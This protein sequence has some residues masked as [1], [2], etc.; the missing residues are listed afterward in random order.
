MTF[1][2]TS[3]DY[4]S[5]WV[6]EFKKAISIYDLKIKC[7]PLMEKCLDLLKEESDGGV[8]CYNQALAFCIEMEGYMEEKLKHFLN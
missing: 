5:E 1:N 6:V 8:M 3:M 4:Y 2:K 7:K